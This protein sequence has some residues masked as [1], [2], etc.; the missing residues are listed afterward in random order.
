MLGKVFASTVR[1]QGGRDTGQVDSKDE[2][3]TKKAWQRNRRRGR[4]WG[5]NQAYL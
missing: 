4:A 2:D 5:S 1:Q 3:K